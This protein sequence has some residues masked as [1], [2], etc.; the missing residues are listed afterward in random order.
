M[1]QRTSSLEA[2]RTASQT[3]DP[4]IV[5]PDVFPSSNNPLVTLRGVHDIVRGFVPSEEHFNSGRRQNIAGFDLGWLR[6]ANAS[7][8]IPAYID[9]A[10]PDAKD[11]VKQFRPCETLPIELESVRDVRR[12][13]MSLTKALEAFLPSHIRPDHGFN[14]GS[15]KTEV[16][17]ARAFAGSVA[18]RGDSRKVAGVYFHSRNQHG[19]VNIWRDK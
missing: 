7:K 12:Y 3:H 11:M 8:N 15:P 16:E 1:I 19:W 10:D 13:S 6:V 4:I 17:T 18:I 14:I 9:P 2:A 5:V